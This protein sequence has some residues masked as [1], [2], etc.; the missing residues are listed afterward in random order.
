MRCCQNMEANTNHG[1]QRSLSAIVELVE[2]S[3]RN[4]RE[5]NVR[6]GKGILSSGDLLPGFAV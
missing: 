4:Q 2:R 6:N 1:A 5:F 3:V